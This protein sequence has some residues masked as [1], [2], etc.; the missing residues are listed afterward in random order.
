MCRQQQTTSRWVAVGL[1]EY[2]LFVTYSVVSLAAAKAAPGEEW[3][4]AFVGI[5]L[6]I[7]DYGVFL[8]NFTFR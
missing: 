1:A 6:R 7:L 2:R 4:A 8:L 5:D 3:V